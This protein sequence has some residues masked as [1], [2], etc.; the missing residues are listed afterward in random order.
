MKFISRIIKRIEVMSKYGHHSLL[1]DLTNAERRELGQFCL[2]YC[3]MNVGYKKHK[4]LPKFSIVKGRVEGTYGQ[5]FTNKIFIYYNEC[6]SVG[7]FVDTFIHEYTHH[8]Q[9]LRSY[10]KVLS[11]VGYNNHPL[12][13]EANETA[14]KYKQ[15]CLE[16][17][18]K[19]KIND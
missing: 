16:Q 9:D 11:K 5:Y 10:Q 19:L 1:T 17:F 13:I 7:K 6:G 8:L 18:R 2:D 3:R 15:D 12:E 14:R 4:G